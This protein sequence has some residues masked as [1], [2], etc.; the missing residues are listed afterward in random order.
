MEKLETKI[1]N[2]RM[3]TPLMAVSG[4]YGIDYEHILPSKEYIGAVVTKSITLYPR[5]GNKEPRIIET[6]AGLLNAIGLQN[7]G[8]DVFINEEIPKLR[9]IEVPVIASIAGSTIDEFVKC[10]S[11]IAERDE[12]L[13]IELNVSCPNAETAGIEFGC[14]SHILEKLVAMVSKVSHNKTL[15]VKLTPNVT[16]IAATAEAAINGGANVISLINT[17]RGMSIDLITKKPKLGNRVGGLSGVG[18]HPV[19]VYMIRQ[20]FMTCCAKSKIPIIGI[21][22]VRNKEEALEFVLAGA[23]CVG[24]GTALFRD[25]RKKASETIF[26]TVAKGML[27]Y[28]EENNAPSINL[29]VGR[30]IPERIFSFQDIANFLEITDEQ[31]MSLAVRGYLPGTQSGGRWESSEDEIG[32]WYNCL[33]GQQWADYISGGT[34]DPLSFS[35][36][37]KNRISFKD[38]IN[39]L[40]N[41]HDA[42]K[43]KINKQVM[44]NDYV[45]LELNFSDFYKS[46]KRTIPLSARDNIDTYQA[47]I[48]VMNQKILITINTQGKLTL[49]LED[50]L[51][52]LPQAERQSIKRILSTFSRYLVQ[53]ITAVG[54]LSGHKQVKDHQPLI[55]S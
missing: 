45:V 1:G 38:Y 17:L 19:A 55:I 21:G 7:P 5:S 39:I 34:L 41:L 14:N 53:Q 24:I 22:G 11:A 10:A 31:A 3:K 35:S 23:N 50:N 29:M 4:I 36:I 48:I 30:A 28:V 18:I 6:S 33:T 49:A 47:N 16:D 43:I 32:D 25:E 15:I 46:I 27:E 42:G 52:D 2:I 20:C 12:I 44:H 9:K 51:G 13:G 37:I 54:N 8:L 40:Q 26:E